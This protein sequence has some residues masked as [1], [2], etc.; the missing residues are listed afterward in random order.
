MQNPVRQWT[1]EKQLQQI[2]KHRTMKLALIATPHTHPT[3]PPLGPAV[4]SAYLQEKLPDTTVSIFDLSLEY[5]LSSFERIKEG[6]MGIRL[7]KWN[8]KMT[9]QNLEQAIIFLRNWQPCHSDLQEYHH[10]ATIFLS[11]ENVFNAFM[12]E[13]AQKALTGQTIPERIEI[14]FKDL[15]QPVLAAKPDLIGF[16]ILYQQQVVFAA[17]LAKLIKEQSTA[18]IV[19]GGAALSVMAA[20]EKLLITPLMLGNKDTP[21]ILCKDFFDYL[22]PGEGER[23]LSCLCQVRDSTDLVNVPNL[24]YFNN[25][26][27]LVNPPDIAESE[28]LPYPDFSQFKLDKYLT[29]EPILPVMTSRGCPWGKCSFCTHH[30]SYLRYR[31]RRI[32]ECVAEIKFLQKQ[33][34][35]NLFYFYDEMIPPKR[36]KTLAEKIIDEGLEIHYGAYAKPVKNFNSDLCTL[37]EHSGCRVLQW[38]VE[39]ASQRVLDLMNKG[40]NIHEV[41]KV[42]SNTSRA[43]MYNLVFILFGF[44]S[45]TTEE[46]QQTLAFLDHNRGNI[47][48]LSSGTFVMTEGSKVYMQSDK[49]FISHMWE[50]QESSILYPAIDYTVS[51]GMSAKEVRQHH[52]DKHSFLDKIPLSSRFGTYREHLLVY[53]ARQD[54]RESN[55][56]QSLP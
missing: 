48:A 54:K 28:S 14:F 41:E 27:L 19:A 43:G 38:G 51:Q 2:I 35:C 36:F 49:F 56:K 31:T 4:L 55:K 44:P 20:P 1:H 15:I 52:I 17:L 26:E 7:Y 32:E 13:M 12:A 29:P 34:N 46:L 42:L 25:N 10:W 37:L 11:F 16:S 9:A 50:R 21:A 33:H 24:I 47:H 45:E 5:Y 23:A 22:I 30:H 40:T 18:K 39:A 3:C 8:E 6:T 53:G